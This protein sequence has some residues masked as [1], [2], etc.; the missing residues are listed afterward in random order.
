MSYFIVICGL[1]GSTIFFVLQIIGTIVIKTFFE[2][3]VVV[4]FCLQILCN[5]FLILRRIE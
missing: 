1:S 4:S 2:H 3:I 5:T